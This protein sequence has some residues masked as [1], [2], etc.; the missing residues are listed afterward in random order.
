MPRS[1]I[2]GKYSEVVLDTHELAWAAGL[3]DGEGYVGVNQQHK[4]HNPK[5][6]VAISQKDKFVLLRF[7]R[8][9]LKLGNLRSCVTS[10]FSRGKDGF[11]LR[12]SNFEDSQAVMALIWKYLSPVKRKQ[13]QDA[14]NTFRLNWK[15]NLRFN[16][17][18]TS[19]PATVNAVNGLATDTIKS[20]G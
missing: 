12:T 18:P 1:P 11:V 20:G 4:E 14:V 13:F 8:A 7:K 17:W 6:I 2:D 5:L 16:N 19:R 10:G 9:T 3:F 15:G